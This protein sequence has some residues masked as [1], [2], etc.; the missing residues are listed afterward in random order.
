MSYKMRKLLLERLSEIHNRED[1]EKVGEEKIT[2]VSTD[3]SIYLN[4][5]TYRYIGAMENVIEDLTLEIPPNKITAIVGASGS[6]KTTLMKI[7]LKFYVVNKGDIKIGNSDLNN[8]SQRY[9]RNKCGVVMQEGYIFNDTIAK[10]IA[11][12]ETN[13]DKVKLVQ[14]ANI[15]NIREFIEELPLAYNT[16][17]AWRG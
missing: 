7:L 1:E 14:A 9:W 17:L 6:G 15:A 8:I 2:E 13:I 5:I 3:A 12:G 4:N 11:V 10:N 16:K